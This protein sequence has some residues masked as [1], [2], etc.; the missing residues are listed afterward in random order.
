MANTTYLVINLHQYLRTLIS[1]TYISL[2]NCNEVY[3]INKISLF[4][5]FLLFENSLFQLNLLIASNKPGLIIILSV[6]RSFSLGKT[7]HGCER[8]LHL[9]CCV[10]CNV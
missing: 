6:D 9:V 8:T 1:R 7:R 4:D 2:Q 5:L 10:M 3:K